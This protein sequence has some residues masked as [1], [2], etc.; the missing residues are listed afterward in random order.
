MGSTAS[1]LCPAR[2]AP[3]LRPS[4]F[5]CLVAATVVAL[6]TPGALHAAGHSLRF[7]GTGTGDVDRV[8]IRIDDPATSTPG[9]SANVGATD[10]TLELWVK[11]AAGNNA[12]A[13]TCGANANWINGNMVVDR[14]RFNQDRKFGIAIA[15]GRIVFGMAGDGTGDRTLCGTTIV[16]DGNWHHVAV[17]RRRSD[18]WMW[19]FVDGNL[20]AQVDG[21][22]GDVSYPSDGIPGDFCGGPCSNSDPFLVLGAEK[23]DAG[24]AFPSFVGWLDEM[25][26]SRT[27][28]YNANFSRPRAPFVR[29]GATVTLHHFDEG[30]GGVVYDTAV[31]PRGP[32]DGVS[33]ATAA[34]FPQWSSDTPF[35]AAAFALGAGALQFVP[36]VSGFASPVDVV[37]PPDG[38]GRL[39]VV[40]QGGLVRIVSGGVI[41][42]QPFL[43]LTTRTTGGGERGLL[44]L[45]FHP[46]YQVNGR[47]FAFYTRNSDG[48][49]VLERFDRDP[50]NANRALLSSGQ[51][52]LTIPHSSASNHNGGKLAFRKDGY[53][54]WSTGDGGSGNDPENN[55]QMLSSRLGKMLRLNVDVETTPYYAIPPDNPFATS[56]CVHRV[57]GTCP[58][59][60][61]LGLRNPFRY[62]FDR[63]TGDLFIGDVGQG[64][65]EEIDLEAIG[66]P[67]GRNYGWRILEGN[68]CNP[69]FG[70]T[71]TPPANYVPPILDYDHS[72]GVSVT[73]GYRYRGTRIPALAGVY[74]YTDF[75]S[76]RVWGATVDGSGAWTTAFLLTATPNISAFGEDESGELY[77]AGYFDGVL[78]RIVPPDTDGDGLPDWWETLYF[79]SATGATAGI[80]TDV[81]GSSNAAEFAARSDPLESQSVPVPYAG[82]SPAFSTGN[83]L[84]CVVGTGCSATINAGGVTQ[85]T[86]W[87]SGTLPAGIEFDAATGT[88]GGVPVPGSQGLWMQTIVA[89]TGIPPVAVQAFAVLVVA[90]CGGFTDVPPGDPFC[91]NVEWLGN[92]SVTQGCAPGSYCPSATV[93]RLA[94][95]AFMN[96][97]GTALT[98]RDTFVD[99]APG[100][101]DP[102]AGAGPVVCAT[103]ALPLATFPRLGEVAFT[104]SARGAG[105]MTYRAVPVMSLDGGTSWGAVNASAA[106]GS[107]ASNTWKAA[108]G[109]GSM[110]V[111]AAESVRF[112]IRVNRAGGSADIA[113]STCQLMVRLHNRD[114]TSIPHDVAH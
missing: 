46:G 20:D 43:D 81:D 31:A 35:N 6:A 89:D 3:R 111:G 65:R 104:F 70:A 15:G 1:K 61:A 39:M 14:D 30:N 72:Q 52:L 64:A 83:A 12:P 112:G 74:L 63:L 94:M 84:V 26:I 59:I 71:C 49:L 2:C 78:Y 109:A 106:Y 27:L 21:P 13:V 17:Q 75:S 53:L 41:L 33:R 51:V 38:S 4:R 32:S 87:R 11:T 97:L 58:E 62:G 86:L 8:K 16:T 54:Y 18:G 25:R 82:T 45:A 57:S 101:L 80:D 102:D 66:T 48:A 76:R 7:N 5:W 79:G 23:H 40:E 85:A 37:A 29:D 60:W 107:P 113:D 88:I 28:R 34:G 10:F 96:R 77:A 99:A 55:G 22:D 95:A 47:L 90:P 105:S 91:A 19:I 68:A 98:P 42:P 103:A 93:S 69:A 50:A 110:W 92:R 108:A 73:G 114:T 67:G 9:P 56:T 100:A 44:S 24:P 36:H